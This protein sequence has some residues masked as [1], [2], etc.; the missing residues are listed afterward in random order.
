MFN[1]FH[2]NGQHLTVDRDVTSQNQSFRREPYEL[3]ESDHPALAAPGRQ[4]ATS[5]RKLA[6]GQCRWV[7]STPPDKTI[8]CGAP[9][10]EGSWCAWHR[11]I[12][13]AEPAAARTPPG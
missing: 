2:F 10:K 6:L 11:R 5:L 1:Y 4:Y 12:V 13:Y 7:L 8:Y 3:R 9:A